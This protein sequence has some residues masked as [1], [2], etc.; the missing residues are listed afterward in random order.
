MRKCSQSRGRARYSL[1]DPSASSLNP[2]AH[3]SCI[4]SAPRLA[5]LGV[6]GWQ[7]ENV[8]TST[9]ACT[10]IGNLLEMSVDW[11]WGISSRGTGCVQ[12]QVPNPKITQGDGIHWSSRISAP[13]NRTQAPW[14]SFQLQEPVTVHLF[15]TVPL[16]QD[17]RF[18]QHLLNAYCMQGTLLLGSGEQVWTRQ[19]S[20]PRVTYILVGKVDSTQD[21][22]GKHT[23]LGRRTSKREK[24]IWSLRHCSSVHVK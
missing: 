11:S 22:S 15:E 19:T 9:K 21:Q 4:S 2:Q 23:V 18:T 24:C 20:P 12:F 13:G 14:G 17:G 7:P 3:P 1:E 6:L 5:P 10:G 16:C 8:P